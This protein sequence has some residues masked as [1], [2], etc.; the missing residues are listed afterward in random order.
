MVPAPYEYMPGQL[1]LEHRQV[2]AA[3]QEAA[4]AGWAKDG[5]LIRLYM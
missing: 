5:V 1:V 4:A 3:G 2:W